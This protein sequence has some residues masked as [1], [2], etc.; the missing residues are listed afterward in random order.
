MCACSETFSH[1]QL[2]VPPWTVACQA[3]LSIDSS[4][5]EYWSEALFPPLGDP[6]DPMTKLKSLKCPVLASGF[7]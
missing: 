6:P 4:R 7:F 2:F 3:P 5:E 1:V